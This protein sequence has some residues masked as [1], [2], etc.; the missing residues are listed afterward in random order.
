MSES[1]VPRP[2]Y[3]VD[4]KPFC[5][6][7]QAAL[8][9]RSRPSRPVLLRQRSY[10]SIHE[11]RWL[12]YTCSGP[13]DPMIE[14]YI[15]TYD[16]LVATYHLEGALS[17]TAPVVV[18]TASS[19][20]PQTIWAENVNMLRT[21]ASDSRIV[22]FTTPLR[23][24]TID[25]NR[26]TPDTFDFLEADLTALFTA[27]RISKAELL[28]GVGLAGPTVGR[29]GFTSIQEHELF[30]PKLRSMCKHGCL[31]TTETLGQLEQVLGLTCKS[32][33]G[34]DM[35]KSLEENGGLPV[36]ALIS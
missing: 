8:R 20:H 24:R 18:L 31:F 12:T 15:T 5:I 9:I 13:T 32:M 27:L 30:P 36:K 4:P 7:M 28:I 25:P 22:I 10:I 2:Y 1:G 29:P 34:A 33:N 3:R 11:P 35:G 16:G 19:L 26:T 14:S 17:H 21:S 6:S 23:S